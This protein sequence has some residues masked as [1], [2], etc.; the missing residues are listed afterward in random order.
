[1]QQNFLDVDFPT[2]GINP[3]VTAIGLQR[4][5]I[6]GVG[7]VPFEIRAQSGPEPRLQHRKGHFNTPEEI[8]FHPVGTGKQELISAAVF[9][10][11]DA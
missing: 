1:V 10:P 9:E 7:E 2:R 4:P 11:V 6:G 3:A 8:A 5:G